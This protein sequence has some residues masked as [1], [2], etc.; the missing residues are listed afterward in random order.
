MI[1]IE[2]PYRYTFRDCTRFEDF[3]RIEGEI[4][5]QMYNRRITRFVRDGKVFYIKCHWGIGWKEIVKSLSLLRLPVVGA[6]QEWQAIACLHRLGIPTMKPV[7]LGVSGL[8]PA[9][10]RSFL[11]TEDLGPNITLDA[12]SKR[13][14]DAPPSRAL[15]LALLGEVARIARTVHRHGFNHRD[16]YLCHFLLDLSRGEASYDP[17]TLRLILIDLHRAQLRAVTPR[18]WLVKDVG[19]LYFSAMDI[20]LTKRDLLRFMSLYQGTTLRATLGRDAGFWQAVRERAEAL[21]RKAHRR[22]APRL[23]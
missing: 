17:K 9:S 5:K 14:K 16:F 8:S 15:K 22:A 2:G 1:R 12:L 7:A 10:Q 21:Y 3:F 13:W 11:I 20:G 18:R 23:L 4:A 6:R 19:S